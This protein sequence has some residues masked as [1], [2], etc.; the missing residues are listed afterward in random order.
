MKPSYASIGN[1]LYIAV[2][3][4][5]GYKERITHYIE[6]VLYGKNKKPNRVRF[7][8]PERAKAYAQERIDKR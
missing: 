4:H 5:N 7:T 8:S 6:P 1:G 2:I 3:S